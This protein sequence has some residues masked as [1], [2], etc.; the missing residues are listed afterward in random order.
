MKINKRFKAAGTWKDNL[1]YQGSLFETI[2]RK[3]QRIGA[4]VK[5]NTRDSEKVFAKIAVSMNSIE[6]A[7]NYLE[8]EIPA[9]DF[10]NVRLNAKKI[11]NEE[12]SKIII[13]G[14]SK[15]QKTIFYSSLYRTM[16]MPRNRT[17]DNP[18][19][20]NNLP[21]WDDH[22]CIWDTWKTDFP[23]QIL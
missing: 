10:E 23:L 13:E 7:V 8:S 20:D 17:D 2:S 11:W 14:V 18:N 9:W 5:F 3:K 19:S 1:K 15:E 6:N 21:Y 12:L 16:M 22:Y 4:F